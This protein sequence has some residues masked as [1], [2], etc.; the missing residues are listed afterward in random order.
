MEPTRKQPLFIVSGASGIGKTTACE[1]LFH[2]EKDYVVLESDILWND[3]Y[4]TPENKYRTYRRM[5]LNLCAGV[6]QIG[7]PCVLCGCCMPDQIEY[8]PERALFTQVY[9]LAV[10]GSDECM[11]RR[12]TQGRG[13]TD[14]KWIESSMHFNRWLR[15]NGRTASPSIEIVDATALTPEETSERIEKWI[16]EK[17]AVNGEKAPMERRGSEAD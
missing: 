17:M 11:R 12:L 6:S 1:L 16:R 13:V 5:W 15:E 2:R 7:M 9:Y 10:V 3:M 8:L 4:N 14:E